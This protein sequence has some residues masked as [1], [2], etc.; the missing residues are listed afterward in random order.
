M[1]DKLDSD[2]AVY[3]HHIFAINIYFMVTRWSRELVHCQFKKPTKSLFSPL[4][5]TCI[6]FNISF[7]CLYFLSW[8]APS[9]PSPSTSKLPFQRTL[10]Q[11]SSFS[12]FHCPHP[13]SPVQPLL[14]STRTLV[15]DPRFLMKCL[16]TM[17]VLQ[18]T[19][20]DWLVWSVFGER[21]AVMDEDHSVKH[22]SHFSQY[23]WSLVFLV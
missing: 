23:P 20:V 5:S 13:L 19:H 4:L 21:N 1:A 2:S 3:I 15:V 11:S 18:Q 8:S 6:L 14:G 9:F 16:K 12:S 17:W 10:L 22:M 7:S